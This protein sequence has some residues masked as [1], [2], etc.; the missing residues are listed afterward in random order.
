M[1]AVE[2]QILSGDEANAG[3]A[4]ERTGMTELIGVAEATGGNIGEHAGAGLLD[5]APGRLGRPR[6]AADQAVGGEQ[7]GLDFAD[8]DLARIATVRE[9]VPSLAN[10]REI[11]K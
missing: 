11:A 3:A 4:Q 10:R 9:Q 6:H 7:A 5:R 2:Q 8:L 1:P